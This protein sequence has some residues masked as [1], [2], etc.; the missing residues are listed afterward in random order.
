[1]PLGLEL[2][3]FKKRVALFSTSSEDRVAPLP[4]IGWHLF[5]LSP[6]AP[7]PSRRSRRLKA[8]QASAQSNKP[9]DQTVSVPE[10]SQYEGAPTL[11]LEESRRTKAF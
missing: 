10:V 7:G 6:A 4:K 3:I 1:M 5:R 2:G 9:G 8:T 11:S